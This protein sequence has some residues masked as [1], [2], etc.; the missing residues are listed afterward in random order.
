MV[1]FTIVIFEQSCPEIWYLIKLAVFGVIILNNLSTHLTFSCLLSIQKM[2]SIYS[3]NNWIFCMY[4]S[5]YFNG[6]P[7][8][9]ILLAWVIAVLCE[10]WK[11]YNEIRWHKT[12]TFKW[13]NNVKKKSKGVQEKANESETLSFIYSA[14]HT[15]LSWKP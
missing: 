9:K 8:P 5:I 7:E 6:C 11:L 12:N 10:F 4:R 14:I 13:T 3:F 1:K 2:S 15:T